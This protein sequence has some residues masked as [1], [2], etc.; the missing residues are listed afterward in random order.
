MLT[1]ATDPEIVQRGIVEES[2]EGLRWRFGKKFLFIHVINMYKHKNQ[3]YTGLSIF[4]FI[5]FGFCHVTLYLF[6]TSFFFIYR[7]L[8]RI[9]VQVS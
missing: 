1:D 7:V 5:F 3:I 8:M 4:G 9:H 2:N 6:S